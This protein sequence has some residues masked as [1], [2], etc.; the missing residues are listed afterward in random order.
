M[1]KQIKVNGQIHSFP[2]DATDEEINATLGG[3]Q[4]HSSLGHSYKDYLQGY[5]SQLL[6][7]GAMGGYHVANLPSYA[8]EAITGEPLYHIPKPDV[9]EFIPHSEA[10]QT[11]KHVGETVSDLAAL[12]LP[13]RIVQ[14]GFRAFSRYH[15]LTRGQ[16]G[17]QHQG[18]M[19][20]AEEAGVRSPL[21]ARD[22]YELDQL[23]SHPA[24]E[25][26]GSTG[27][28]LT[29]MGRAAI[30]EGA[31]QGLPSALH[32]GQSNL[33][34]LERAIPGLGESELANT[35]VRPL[36]NRILEGFDQAMRQ[37]GL[38]EEANDLI[39]ARQGARRHYQTKKTLKSAGKAIV[40]PL[41]I[42]AALKWA[43]SGVKKLP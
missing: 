18:P 32:S 4:S 3:V 37:A 2:D 20:A 41:G 23:L 6:Q 42:G 30:V 10:G 39:Q 24:L 7:S 26:G 1:A 28:S 16:I 34:Y 15:P 21:S 13:G 22:A 5:G 38:H 9:T 12:M 40:K 19:A 33:G 29:P 43:L 35:R 36:K 14:R 27:K 25:S 8:Y 11:G 17:R 31:A